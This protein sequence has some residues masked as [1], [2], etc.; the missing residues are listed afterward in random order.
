MGVSF[1]ETPDS[2]TIHPSVPK[3]AVIDSYDD[4]R[5]AMSFAIAGL[6]TPNVGI[7]DPDCVVKTCPHFFDLLGL[8]H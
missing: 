2:L 3:G 6:I 8:L 7:Q 4:H 5:I 1:N